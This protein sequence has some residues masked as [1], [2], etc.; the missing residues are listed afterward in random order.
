MVTPT[1]DPG[2]KLLRCIDS[3]RQQTYGNI[4]HIIVDGSSKDGTPERLA[5]LNPPV[6]WVSE[7]DSGQADG[8]NKGFAMSNGAILS[9]LN[10][11]DVL[12]PNAVAAVVSR[13]ERGADVVYGTIEVTCDRKKSLRRPPSVITRHSFRAGNPIA[14]PGTA[15]RA[16]LL[17]QTGPIDASMSLAMDLE[18][19][20]RFLLAQAKFE[21]CDETLATFEVHPLS[22]TSSTPMSEFWREI[23]RAFAQN[24]W[25]EESRIALRKAALNGTLELILVEG[26]GERSTYAALGRKALRNSELGSASLLFG[27]SVAPG[28]ARRCLRAYDRRRR[29]SG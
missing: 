15:F 7:P 12:K 8:L 9:W 21:R 28:I 29:C 25:T 18:L 6:R 17:K 20:V 13:L 10:A 24:G 26:D 14:Q 5:A 23:A 22:K 2:D 1:R 27:S 4:E 19:W 11:D 3:V 16:D